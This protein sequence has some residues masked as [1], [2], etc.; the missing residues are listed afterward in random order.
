MEIGKC[1]GVYGENIVYLLFG[2]YCLRQQCVRC[3]LLD[4]KWEQIEC[5]SIETAV[6][7]DRHQI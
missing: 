4:G 5:A 1:L 7:I 6:E 2:D 3:K